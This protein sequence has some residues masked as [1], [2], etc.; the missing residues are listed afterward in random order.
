LDKPSQPAYPCEDCADT[1][2]RF[3]CDACKARYEQEQE[4]KRE[5]ENRKRQ[6]KNA[7]QRERYKRQKQI[8][9]HYAKARH[10]DT[11]GEELKSKR[12]DARYCSSSCRQAAYVK[13]DGNA[14]NHKP[15][16]SREIE[17]T[18]ENVFACN[19]DSAL[20][21]EDLCDYAFPGEQICR[22]YRVAVVAA[23][24][25]I[26]KQIGEHR[27]WRRSGRRGGTWVFWNRASVTSYAMARLKGEWIFGDYGGSAD[28]RAKREAQFKADI[29][30]GGRYHEY[31]VRGGSWWKH[32][33]E[34]L[35]KFKDLTANPNNFNDD[36]T[37]RHKAA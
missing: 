24:K 28:W 36:L 30:P 32:C 19:P 26:S 5:L 25:K 35:E 34:D 17:A 9:A 1:T 12:S 31:V 2:P 7:K 6:K 4:K 27:D 8:K 14:S 21:V 29:A 37:R 33:Q 15:V 23:A 10:C 3:Y 22:K 13:R 11:C 20:T 18:I 16:S